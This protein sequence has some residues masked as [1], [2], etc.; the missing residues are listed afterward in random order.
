[1]IEDYYRILGVSFDATPVEIKK[2]YRRL[3]LRFHPDVST[4]AADSEERFRN[5]TQA[6]GVLIDPDK[7]KRY[8]QDR[9]GGFQREEVFRDIF[10]HSE[11]RDVLDDL[12]LKQEWLDKL[13]N[14]SRA[15]AC[16]TLIYG[17]GPKEILKRGLVRL[18]VHNASRL[19]HN[20]MD[21]H[22]HIEI[23]R[24]IMSRGGYITIEYRPGFSMRRIKVGIP[25]STQPG[26]VLRVTG[27]GR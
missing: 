24:E 9:S 19:F 3:A 4:D 23:S 26:T 7:R 13:F 12:P 21:I 25:R 1:M 27:M 10:S 17:G 20:V 22:E 16:E 8:D 6:Y 2:A 15:I 11:F 18:A 14:I 5:I